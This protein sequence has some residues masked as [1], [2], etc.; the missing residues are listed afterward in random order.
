M[1]PRLIGSWSMPL[2]NRLWFRPHALNWWCV[3]HD[4]ATWRMLP[5]TTRCGMLPQPQARELMPI[6]PMPL[7]TAGFVAHAV[8]RS[9]V[10]HAVA[11][12]PASEHRTQADPPESGRF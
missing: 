9:S 2:A 1:P 5:G 10:A 7:A 4:S 3:P 8:A 12:S 6:Q 11:V